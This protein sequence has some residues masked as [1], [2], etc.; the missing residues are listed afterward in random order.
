MKPWLM[1]GGLSQKSKGAGIKKRDFRNT[2][3]FKLVW[4][5]KWYIPHEGMFPIHSPAW[6]VLLVGKHGVR[7]SLYPILQEYSKTVPWIAPLLVNHPSMRSKS[8]FGIWDG[9]GHMTSSNGSMK[10]V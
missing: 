9:D 6:Q 8:V 2:I 1:L 7:E 5:L 3:Y 10:N 4:L